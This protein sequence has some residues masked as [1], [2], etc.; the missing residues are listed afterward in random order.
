M[1]TSGAR[2]WN[3]IVIANQIIY[4]DDNECDDPDGIRIQAEDTMVIANMFEG[5]EGGG[6]T[7]HNGDNYQNPSA[8]FNHFTNHGSGSSVLMQGE[9][10]RPRI[11]GNLCEKNSDGAALRTRVFTG[12]TINDLMV[13]SNLVY[14]K[15]GA[16]ATGA[17][18]ATACS[19]QVDST[20]TMAGLLV[21]SNLFDAT[22]WPENGGNLAHGVAFAGA[23]VISDALIHGNVFRNY[24]T[25]ANVIARTATGTVTGTFRITDSNLG[26]SNWVKGTATLGSGSSSVAV[27]HGLAT[28]LNFDT[29]RS[30]Y[31]IKIV[32]V[33]PL[34]T[35]HSW[36]VSGYT[37]T[38]FTVTSYT[39]TGGA[40]AV[41]ANFTFDWEI[42]KRE[43]TLS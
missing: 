2:G 18:N 20:A 22:D 27:T 31:E 30:E 40:V 32:P 35:A 24:P 33:S 19:V 28:P 25:A 41:G 5:V 8:L 9:T 42:Y 21:S 14:Y 29:G 36:A 37:S 4:D 17:V 10:M 26:F 15:S 1:T 23:G 3:G 11:I 6:I 43:W 13:Q 12:E 7:T 16:T 39:S 38:G 34:V